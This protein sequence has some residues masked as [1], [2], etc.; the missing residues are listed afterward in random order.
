MVKHEM[1]YEVGS[2]SSQDSALDGAA[3][4]ILSP[5]TQPAT[6]ESKPVEIDSYYDRESY[7]F[8]LSVEEALMSDRE[9]IEYLK[10]PQTW[11]NGKT[12]TALPVPLGHN[13][14]FSPAVRSKGI[15]MRRAWEG[16]FRVNKHLVA[17]LRITVS[18]GSGM[19]HLFRPYVSVPAL[20]NRLWSRF[21]RAMPFKVDILKQGLLP[22]LQR[23][24]R[25]RRNLLSC[26]FSG[27]T[28]FTR[29][30]TPI[31]RFGVCATKTNLHV[32]EC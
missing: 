32:L 20:T 14:D 19:F 16:Q 8:L 22:K 27:G 24:C 26:I 11:L 1:E 7:E 10:W 18:N 25:C 6:T 31:N 13:T 3:D 5:G 2:F 21:S 9:S 29:T 23:G 30:Y 15:I 12:R 4:E 17:L 28:S